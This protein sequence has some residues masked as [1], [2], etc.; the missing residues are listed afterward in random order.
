MRKRGTCV[1]WAGSGTAA[2]L[3]AS[4]TVS[5]ARWA[6]WEP[7]SPVFIP[8]DLFVVTLAVAFGFSVSGLIAGRVG[9]RLGRAAA[10][11]ALTAPM[12][13]V[14]SGVVHEE[15]AP[16]KVFVA[17]GVLVAAALLAPA[18]RSGRDAPWPLEALG[19]GTAAATWLAVA[20]FAVSPLPGWIFPV[21][22][23]ALLARGVPRLPV[24]RSYWRLGVSGV[25]LAVT[26]LCALTVFPAS[27]QLAGTRTRFAPREGNS[28][29][30]IVLDTLRQD[31]LS[32]YGYS[33]KT[34]PHLDRWAQDALVFTNSSSTGSW[35][36]PSHASMFTGLSVRRHGAHGFR[37]TEPGG[38]AYPLSD[39]HVT[40]AELAS[41]AR[42]E[43][44][45]LAANH[46]YVSPRYGLDQGFDTFWCELP[47]PGFRFAPSDWLIR[48]LAPWRWRQFSWLYY[49]DRY[50]TDNALRWLRAVR[51]RP[52][53][54][55]LNYMDVHDPNGRPPLPEVPD[56]QEDPVWLRG[57]D[58]W[59]IIRG[60][61]PMTDEIRRFLINSYD[62]ELIH[63]DGELQ[64]LFEFIERTGLDRTTTVVVTSD[65]GE[66]FG[67]H[68]LVKHGLDL[69]DDVIRVPLIVKAPGGPS[70]R[71]NKPVQ[72]SDLFP[73]ILEQLRVP[74]DGEVDG[75]SVF[76][77]EASEI[78]SEWYP[79]QRKYALDPVFAGRFDRTIRALQEGP[80]KLS[81]DDRGGVVLYDRAE[82][83]GET[84]DQ[85][86]GRPEVVRALLARLQRWLADHPPPQRDES[87]E[88][89]ILSPDALE[90][91]KALGYVE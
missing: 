83:P 61:A 2:G 12:V 22:V 47:R 63:L 65:H 15:A 37:G 62:R 88:Q 69:H 29:I 50:V 45:G 27:A 40:I 33:R 66:Y 89:G 77:T 76:G 7:Y 60:D 87:E 90:R 91:L 72:G 35:T 49:R 11:V 43:T 86:P 48:K 42:L 79:S 9:D 17:I 5:L 80:L 8:F 68:G 56:E 19:L 14:W 71:S 75:R 82:D 57:W 74:Y 44:A 4:A 36:L 78:V 26:A 41:A 23:L 31:H 70:G 46:I 25:S 21:V 67:D 39:D 52:F 32:L 6:T 30:L 84:I 13:F 81:A 3:L 1:R 20:G 64:R 59:S 16:R 51:G 58:Y 54:L 34:T 85:G 10:A 28:V 55:F 38:N 18:V 53:F 73:T 24:E